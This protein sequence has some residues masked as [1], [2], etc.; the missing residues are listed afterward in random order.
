MAGGAA[1]PHPRDTSQTHA[2]TRAHPAARHRLFADPGLVMA[3]STRP[4]GRAVRTSDGYRVSGRWNLVSGCELA[5][6]VLLRCV[7]ENPGET[8][9]EGPPD[10]IMAYLPS[11][12]CRVI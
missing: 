6:L 3:N 11:E 5:T 12:K 4:T 10:L 9:R 2:E 7:V 1:R 8:R